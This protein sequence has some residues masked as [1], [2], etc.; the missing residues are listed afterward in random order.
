M[1]QSVRHSQAPKKRSQKKRKTIARA[2]NDRQSA[3]GYKRYFLYNHA[4]RQIEKA[5]AGGFYIEC[6]AILD[7][8]IS[9]RLESR[10]AC[11]NPEDDS[12][13]VFGTLGQLS[14]NL[15]DEETADDPGIHKLYKRIITWSEKRNTAMH[16][17]VKYGANKSRSAWNARY[18]S[19]RRTVDSGHKLAREIS[20][21]VESLNRKDRKSR[22]AKGSSKP[23]DLLAV[24][25][26]QV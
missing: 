14:R 2:T 24:A 11:I 7:S 19:M 5:K 16:Q 1:S 18:K 9:D 12:K 20:D 26:P 25:I 3:V 23:A 13:H 15:L 21:K 17:A 4:Y 10:R 6:I 22:S 8:I